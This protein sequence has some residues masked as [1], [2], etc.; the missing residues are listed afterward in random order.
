MLKMD[1]Q[2]STF[3]E[4]VYPGNETLYVVYTATIVLPKNG[5]KS[6]VLAA[7]MATMTL[8]YGGHPSFNPI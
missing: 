1:K 8:Q 4:L 6:D 3:E 5:Q 7:A 2:D